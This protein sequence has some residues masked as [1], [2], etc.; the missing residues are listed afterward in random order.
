[1]TIRSATR[2]AAA[3]LALPAAAPAAEAPA[4]QRVVK[5]LQA[6]RLAIMANAPVVI[7]AEALL[8]HMVVSAGPAARQ[9][10]T[11]FGAG[12]SG[13][14]QLFWRP[15]APVDTPI[16]NW[17]H[18]RLYPQVAQAGRY[19]VALL[20]TVAPDYGRVR[21]FV[22]G[23]A[24]KDYDG[25]ATAVAPRRLELGEFNLAA[26]TFELVFTVFARNAAASNYYVG[27][28][29]IELSAVE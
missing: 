8:P 28:D 2:L 15:P 16:R 18:L 22:K 20:H 26:G 21:V 27:L 4:L 23:Q 14:A 7:E 12:W 17:P 1:M 3:L 11:G 19:K 29:R 10:M 25:Y 13:D 9:D 24:A 6:E 5:P